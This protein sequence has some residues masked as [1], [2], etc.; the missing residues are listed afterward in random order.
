[1]LR[2]ITF[3]QFYPADSFIHKMDPRSKLL[4]SLLYMIA[5]FFVD[6]FFGF[7]F[8]G[9]MLILMLVFSKVPFK[10][11]IKTVKPVLILVAITALL[12]IFFITSGDV[13]AKFWIIKITTDGVIYSARM[14]LRLIFMVTGAS[15]LTLTTTPLMLTDGLERLLSPLTHIKFP[16][17]ELALIMSIALKYIPS[18]MD[19]T[20]RIIRAQKARGADFDTGNIFKR[21]KAFIPILIPLL[22]SSFRSADELAAAMESR[23]HGYT[24]KRTRLKILKLGVR[25]LIAS[26][27]ICLIVVAL[28]V[29]KYSKGAWAG[30]FPWMYV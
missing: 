15:L 8:I 23:C 11:V 24:S 2:D 10:M 20:D 26:V 7:S 18:L 13:L 17:H 25:D 1:M 4:L 16:V 30:D 27:V 22:I 21:A 12:N 6:S 29:V 19:E 9:L 28:L 3:G 5:V 14:V